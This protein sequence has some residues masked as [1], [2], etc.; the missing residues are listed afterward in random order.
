MNPSRLGCLKLSPTHSLH[1]GCSGLS[2]H[3]CLYRTNFHHY[4]S[5]Y[6]LH[7]QDV[8]P[9]EQASELA[10]KTKIAKVSEVVVYRKLEDGSP[11]EKNEISTLAKLVDRGEGRALVG[12]VKLSDEMFQAVAGRSKKPAVQL[13]SITRQLDAGK[14]VS[15]RQIK[16]LGKLGRQQLQQTESWIWQLRPSTHCHC[17][18]AL[19]VHQDKLRV[20]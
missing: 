12:L 2:V 7:R 13:Q 5:D 14:A 6:H 3:W 10:R 11:L 4:L 17:I 19:Y 16:Q 15:A 9:I 1:A 18:Q 20:G 8:L